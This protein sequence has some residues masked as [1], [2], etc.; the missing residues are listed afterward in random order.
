MNKTHIFIIGL[1]N[2][3]KNFLNLKYKGGWMDRKDR[4]KQT[5]IYIYIYI[6]IN[7]YIVNRF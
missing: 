3:K 2:K 7:E 6:F 1:T 4:N 5:N